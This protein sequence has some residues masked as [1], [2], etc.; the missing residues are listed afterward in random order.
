MEIEAF[1]FFFKGQSEALF[2]LLLEFNVILSN[3]RLFKHSHLSQCT[4]YVHHFPTPTGFVTLFIHK[5]PLL[6]NLTS[7][8]TLQFY[9]YLVLL[10]IAQVAQVLFCT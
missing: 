8:L 6:F 1:F 4:V 5:V 7:V 9:F 10:A 3:Q 2:I